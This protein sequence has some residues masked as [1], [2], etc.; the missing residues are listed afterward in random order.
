MFRSSVDRIRT[1]LVLGLV[2]VLAAAGC[3]RKRGVETVVFGSTEQGYRQ[4]IE[5]LDVGKVGLQGGRFSAVPLDF[6]DESAGLGGRGS[7]MDPHPPA[8]IR[9][10]EGNCPAEPPRPAGHEH[11]ARVLVFSHA[12][13][14]WDDSRKANFRFVRYS[15]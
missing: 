5:H 6:G 7:V 14:A 3:S 8:P 9:K 11:G 1:G 4:G 13:F 2:I 15:R 10:I 12:E